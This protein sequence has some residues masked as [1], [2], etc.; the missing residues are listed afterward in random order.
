[1]L[2]NGSV[3]S[4]LGA[5]FITFVL[6]AGL[7][8]PAQAGQSTQPPVVRAVMLWL[9]GCGHCQYVLEEVLPPLQAQYG[10]QFEIILV[11]LVTTEDFDRLYQTAVAFGIAKD[12]VGVPFLVIGEQALMGSR[13]ISEELPG[14]IEQY[15]AQGGVDYPNLASLADI[16]PTAP[17]PG[18]QPPEPVPGNPIQSVPYSN[19]FTLAM[20]VMLG[21]VASLLIAGASFVR[22]LPGLPR[23]FSMRWTEP[24]FPLLCL[25]GLGV[26]G[27][28]TYV[29]TQ[30]VQAICGPVG[31]CNTVQ[32]S[33]YA[34]LFG[35][36]PVGVLGFMGF[37][38]IL[39]AWLYPRLRRDRWARYAPLPVLGMTVFGVLF[40]I[41]LTYLELFVIK[42]VCI[43]CL[44]SAV[45]MTLLLLLSLNPALRCL[46]GDL[47]VEEESL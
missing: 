31:D 29:E 5:G 14:L 37:L 23:I 27:Y 26:A 3:K 28:L 34:R 40:S 20:L 45:I 47:H 9:E 38:A 16:L 12:K 10:K 25:A 7:A 21:M 41:Y 1:M 19:G 11:Q 30:A 18:S 43:W 24:A 42:A 15:L 2:V 35:V 13:Q 22:G 17:N 33:P 36:L 8:Y 44:T 39:A 4:W 46:I 6:L 32:S